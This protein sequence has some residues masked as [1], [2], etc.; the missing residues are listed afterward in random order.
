MNQILFVLAAVLLGLS[1]IVR[2][3]AMAGLTKKDVGEAERIAR[4]KRIVPISYVLLA[5]AVL[6]II[7]LM[8][9]R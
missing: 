9:T 2:F 4:Y 8:V 6:I 5:P 3:Y 1:L 7:Y